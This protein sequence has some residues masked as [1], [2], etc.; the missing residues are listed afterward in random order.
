MRDGEEGRKGERERDRQTDSVAYTY[1]WNLSTIARH[2]LRA[3]KEKDYNNYRRVTILLL[4]STKLK[5]EFLKEV[6]N[7]KHNAVSNGNTGTEHTV[8]RALSTSSR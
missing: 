3:Y 4:S 7:K 2:N 6:I 5:S 1:Y 8:E